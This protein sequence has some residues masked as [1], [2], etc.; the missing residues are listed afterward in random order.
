MP[1]S[2]Y[3]SHPTSEICVIYGKYYELY[4]VVCRVYMLSTT[5]ILEECVVQART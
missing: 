3:K 2:S 5:E 4:A 1:K